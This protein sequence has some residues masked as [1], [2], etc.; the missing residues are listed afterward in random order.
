MAIDPT[1]RRPGDA[2]PASRR[3]APWLKW[4]VGAL[5]FIAAV[6]IVRQITKG[7]EREKVL[8]P[9]QIERGDVSPVGNGT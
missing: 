9:A 3:A 6:F 2:P 4:A 1:P 7:Q 8:A 5:V